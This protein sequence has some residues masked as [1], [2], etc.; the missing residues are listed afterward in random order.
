[1]DSS[2]NLSI[3]AL[4]GLT[5]IVVVQLLKDN[6]GMIE[7][8]GENFANNAMS[9]PSSNENENFTYR[10]ARGPSQHEVQIKPLP[11]N[12]NHI[13]KHGNTP[14][15]QGGDFFSQPL[16]TD[17]AA[18]NGYNMTP[19]A[20]RVYM[21]TISAATPNMQNFNAISNS[22]ESTNE[23]PGPSNFMSN[24]VEVN[25]QEL[26][27]RAADLSLCAQ[28]MST[29]TSGTGNGAISATLL[30]NGGSKEM[31]VEGFSDCNVQN[32]LANQTFLS[33]RAGGVIGTDTVAGSL[34]NAN[35]SIRS[36]PPNPMQY[37]GP[38]ML[39]TIYPDLLRRPLEGCGPSFGVYGNGPLGGQ[40]P[41]ETKELI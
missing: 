25:E 13:E 6:F 20:Y 33:A 18:A 1:M 31:A 41:V 16:I 30:P 10:P 3:I 23:I 26:T 37:V 29:M 17:T 7:N 39:S 2:K 32:V 34:R 24:Q 12:L 15:G 9:V 22:V 40:V 4:I 38:W 27:G 5:T 19:E 8:Y 21:A 36:D 28:N 14:F 11:N 35:Q